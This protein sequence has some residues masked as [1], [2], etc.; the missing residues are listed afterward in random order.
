MKGKK[1]LQL[2]LGMQGKAALYDI[3]KSDSVSEVIVAD[4][5]PD[6]SRYTATIGS[7]KIKPLNL[8]EIG[9]AS[10]RERV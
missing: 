2:G 4:S 7:E 9:R 1:V 10:C 3:V 5:S 8:D 6:L